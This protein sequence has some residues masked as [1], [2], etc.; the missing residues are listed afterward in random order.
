MD[1][2]LSNLDAS[3]RVRMHMEM[4][5]LQRALSVTAWDGEYEAQLGIPRLA[6][7]S[8]SPSWPTASVWLD[9]ET[10]ARL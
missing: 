8:E 5:R 2:P 9:P 10:E 7:W 6:T 4:R 1:D 3:L